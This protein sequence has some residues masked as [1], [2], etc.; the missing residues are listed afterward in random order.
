MAAQLRRSRSKAGGASTRGAYWGY[1]FHEDGVQSARGRDCRV[2]LMTAPFA[3]PNVASLGK[4]RS[5]FTGRR[6]EVRATPPVRATLREFALK[7]FLAISTSTRPAP[8]DRCRCGRRAARRPCFRPHF[9][10]HRP[11]AGAA[12]RDLVQARLGRRARAGPSPRSYAPWLLFNPLAVY[13]R[14]TPTVGH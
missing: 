6:D 13:Y 2:A 8:L 5:A 14:W 3:P 1:G 12:V 10:W 4:R 11:A 9:R 7:L